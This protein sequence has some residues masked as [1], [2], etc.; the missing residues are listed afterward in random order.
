MRYQLAEPATVVLLLFGPTHVRRAFQLCA[1]TQ[2]IYRDGWNTRKRWEGRETVI[3]TKFSLLQYHRSKDAKRLSLITSNLVIVSDWWRWDRYR[4]DRET[5]GL[6]ERTLINDKKPRG[7][8][9][10]QTSRSLCYLSAQGLL[11][12]KWNV[13]KDFEIEISYSVL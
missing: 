2:V 9:W 11:V 7:R 3:K 6:G 4:S 5:N 13:T 12:L 8:N 1:L 10:K